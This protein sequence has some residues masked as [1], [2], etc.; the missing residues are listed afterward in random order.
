MNY[1]IIAQFETKVRYPEWHNEIVKV[2][3]V[4]LPYYTGNRITGSHWAVD[5]ET[6]S[7]LGNTGKQ[8]NTM[9]F[10]LKKDAENWID[11]LLK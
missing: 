10:W 9:Y 7:T 2:I 1:P 5:Y 6:P 4:G 8:T 3:P 11:S